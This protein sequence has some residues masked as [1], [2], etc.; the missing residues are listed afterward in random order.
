MVLGATMATDP[1]DPFDPFDSLSRLE[2]SPPKASRTPQHLNHPQM[3]QCPFTLAISNNVV[4]AALCSPHLLYAF[5]WN[6][7]KQWQRAF[8]RWSVQIFESLVR[9]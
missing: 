6:F 1:F 7:P 8:G 4:A 5:V 9:R 2:N 3:T